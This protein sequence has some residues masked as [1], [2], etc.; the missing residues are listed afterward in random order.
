MTFLCAILTDLFDTARSGKETI[1]Q[2]DFPLVWHETSRVA[3]LYSMAYLLPDPP[4]PKNMTLSSDIGRLLQV[5]V[6]CSLLPCIWF[7]TI[8]RRDS[9]SCSQSF[10]P[11]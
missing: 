9:P 6:V 7:L 5:L 11:N 8:L 3:A 2:R 1:D 10:T 4:C